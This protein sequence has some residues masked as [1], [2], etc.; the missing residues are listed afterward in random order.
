MGPAR[1]PILARFGDPFIVRNGSGR[2]ITTVS[3]GVAGE[4]AVRARW[5]SARGT[6]RSRAPRKAIMPRL[7]EFDPAVELI[8][9]IAPEQGARQLRFQLDDLDPREGSWL[10]RV[11]ESDRRSA[12]GTTSGGRG[13][14]R[15]HGGPYLHADEVDF[16][17][18]RPKASRISSGG[19]LDTREQSAPPANDSAWCS[20]ALSYRKRRVQPWAPAPRPGRGHCSRGARSAPWLSGRRALGP[21]ASRSGCA[22]C[23]FRARAWS[24]TR[25]SLVSGLRTCGACSGS[26][27][28]ASGSRTRLSACSGS[29]RPVSP[30]CAVSPERLR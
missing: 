2:G 4:R 24:G 15:S 1:A 6:R 29:M 18:D 20:R 26:S 7:D 22:R 16:A 19:C 14:C 17:P 11:Q 23:S 21:S 12:P 10:P 3:G 5:S 8:L 9:L 28:R 25:G 30:G 27:I 13:H